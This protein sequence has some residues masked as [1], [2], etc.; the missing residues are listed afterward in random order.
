MP[1][2]EVHHPSR[3]QVPWRGFSRL[4][5][6]QNWMVGVRLRREGAVAA[7][8]RHPK[9]ICESFV[10][11]AEFLQDKGRVSGI[12]DPSGRRCRWAISLSSALMS[13]PHPAGRPSGAKE[14]DSADQTGVPGYDQCCQCPGQ[15]LKEPGSPCEDLPGSASGVEGALAVQPSV[16]GWQA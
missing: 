10:I 1:R 2:G 4:P 7:V 5:T 14:L 3:A 6:A 13:C 16:D 8:A 15:Y 9:S 11:W 12:L